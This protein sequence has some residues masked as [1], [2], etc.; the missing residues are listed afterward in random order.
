MEKLKIIFSGVITVDEIYYKCN[1][2]TGVHIVVS[3]VCEDKNGKYTV[4]IGSEDF[5]IE[6]SEESRKDKRKMKK[7][8]REM[9]SKHIEKV[10]QDVAER[11]GVTCIKIVLTDDDPV[12]STIVPNIFPFAIHRICLWHILKNFLKALEKLYGNSKIFQ[13]VIPTINSLWHVNNQKKAMEILDKVQSILGSANKKITRRLAKLRERIIKNRIGLLDF[14][15]NNP[16]ESTFARI[17]P[18]IKVIKSFQSEDGMK[19][20]LNSMVMWY[21]TSVFVDGAHRGK[22]P[23]ELVCPAGVGDKITP[24]SYI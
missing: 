7:E 4:I 5:M 22:S 1:G 11:Y 24:F 12:Y 19:N 13:K 2:G 23:I 8:I 3:A 21:N 16:S 10:L 15:T 17:K 18:L 6:L 14:R 20:Y 9:L